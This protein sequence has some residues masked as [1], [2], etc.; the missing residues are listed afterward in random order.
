MLDFIICQC[1]R[2]FMI[3]H[4]I[5]IPAMRVLDRLKNFKNIGCFYFLEGYS[6]LQFT[7]VSSILLSQHRFKFYLLSL[8]SKCK[9]QRHN[10]KQN[11]LSLFPLCPQIGI[12]C[13]NFLVLSRIP[14]NVLKMPILFTHCFSTA[15]QCAP[16]IFLNFKDTISR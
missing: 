14:C 12:Q 1:S 9:T 3:T 11:Y 8:S 5:L 7:T 13:Q 2:H 16:Y 15:K 6:L 10:S 4:L